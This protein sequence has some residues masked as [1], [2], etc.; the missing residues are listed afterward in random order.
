MTLDRMVLDLCLLCY[1]PGRLM[2]CIF[3]ALIESYGC[4]HVQHH[5][6]ISMDTI[7]C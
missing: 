2:L 6:E 7:G 1:T 3:F 5:L 4:M